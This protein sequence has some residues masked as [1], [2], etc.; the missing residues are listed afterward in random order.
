MFAIFA[1]LVSGVGVLA[2]STAVVEPDAPAGGPAGGA[3]WLVGRAL[4]ERLEQPVDVN[5]LAAPLRASLAGLARTQQVAVLLDRRIDPDCRLDLVL[6]DLPLGRAL[7]EIAARQSAATAQLGPL[8]YVGPARS[9]TR[10]RTLAEL[11]RRDAASVGGSIGRRLLGER[12]M[13]WDDL[14][15]PRQ[16]LAALG[17]EAGLEI[18]GL[19]QVPHDLWAGAALPSLP[20][21][22]RITLVAVQFDLTFSIAAD[23]R[24]LRLTP[25]PDRLPGVKTKEPSSVSPRPGRTRAARAPAASAEQRFTL[26]QA[27]GQLR[28]L[29]P[30]L[31]AMLQLE[32]RIDEEA[33]SRAGITLDRPVSVSATDA[34]ANELLQKLLDP[35][36]CT[37]RREG[38]TVVVVPK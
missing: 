34:T 20:L 7:A 21:V 29:L 10:L 12:T 32:L 17:Q 9:A 18:T 8:V 31:A 38:N 26:R 24:S 28:E 25:I 19:E 1:A 14:A 3:A 13:R 6:R 2:A 23:G 33:L 16:L 4:Q 27:K 22:D 35:A 11:R 37:F 30:K 15:E 36:G 5:W